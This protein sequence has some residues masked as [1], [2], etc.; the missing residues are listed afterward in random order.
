M[1]EPEE[2]DN[3]HGG[4]SEQMEISKSQ[5]SD[6]N[7]T[8]VSPGAALSEPEDSRGS[9]QQLFSSSYTVSVGSTPLSPL[10]EDDQD[11]YPSM[12]AIHV[13]QPAEDDQRTYELTKVPEKTDGFFAEQIDS[14]RPMVP[15]S[16]SRRRRSSVSGHRRRSST[17]SLVGLGISSSPISRRRSSTVSN[18]SKHEFEDFQEGDT[19]S[20]FGD[21]DDF[22]QGGFAEDEGFM[23]D[24]QDLPEAHARGEPIVLPEL[25]D[26]EEVHRYVL[27]ATDR[28]L[29]HCNGNF[30]GNP[31]TSVMTME[32]REAGVPESD[33][34]DDSP[35]MLTDRA[36]SLW[37]QLTAPPPLQ[38]PDWK[39]S[40]IR[41]L[42]LVSLGIPVD[43]DEILP[44]MTHKKLI[45][46][47]TRRYKDKKSADERR[48]KKK[49]PPPPEFEINTARRLCSTTKEALSSM[50]ERDLQ[51]HVA[52]LR[53]H[54]AAASDLLTYWL[55]QRDSAQSEKET[56]EQVVSNLVQYHKKQKDEQKEKATSSS[57]KS[58]SRFSMR[59]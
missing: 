44:K 53:A 21:F 45:L 39:R 27:G 41:R 33:E 3:N 7:S 36:V 42:F 56:F 12:P 58:R 29:N 16:P 19:G 28:L 9:A 6:M 35:F 14:L 51:I 50:T 47:S 34:D 48:S 43:L 8:A 38:P 15:N 1:S 10:P 13:S 24:E 4:P 55:E 54:T 5:T 23:D 57:K 30:N 18:G 37:K 31:A 11:G 25:T 49:I 20:D 52:T 46:P 2:H 26:E 22:E 59:G 32:V 40:R 17:N